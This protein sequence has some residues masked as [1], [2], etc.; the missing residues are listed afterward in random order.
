MG[1]L[2]NTAVE[3]AAKAANGLLTRLFGPIADGMEILL[4]QGLRLRVLNNQLRGLKKLEE[5]CKREKINIKQINLKVLFPY[6]EGI[7][8]EEDYELE[9]MWANLI[10]NYLDSNK[11]LTQT[12]YPMILKQ[13]STQDLELLKLCYDNPCITAYDREIEELYKFTDPKTL[14]CGV[15]VSNIER[16]GLIKEDLMHLKRNQGIFDVMIET[17]N[18]KTYVISDFGI[19]FYEACQR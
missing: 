12:V 4:G 5:K 13:L 8:V 16:I 7:S 18:I 6:L 10:A 17:F 1:Q 2:I 11:S 9:E 19:G 3:E 15:D 14:L